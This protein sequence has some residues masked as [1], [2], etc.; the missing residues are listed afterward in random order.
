MKRIYSTRTR[1]VAAVLL[2]VIVAGGF[3][4]TPSLRALAQEIIDF[5]TQTETDEQPSTVFVG[6]GLAAPE[7]EYVDPYTLSLDEIAA[8]AGFDVF[9]PTYIPDIMNFKGGL[10]SHGG[11]RV[12]MIYDCSTPWSLMIAQLK[13]DD[14]ATPLEVGAS[15]VIEAVPIRD[16]IGQYVQGMWQYDVAPEIIENQ[17]EAIEE[18]PVTRV[19]VNELAWKR[20]LWREDGI[21]FTIMTAGGIMNNDTLSPC[22]LTKADYV[23]IAEGL[24]PA[25]TIGQ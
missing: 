18:V 17:G 3:W 1:L 13:V 16:S 6:S 9:L 5:F 22:A 4:A 11:Q 24:Q 21:N 19:W 7:E 14:L 10:V 8:Q 2:G 25:S 15:A 12:E 23:A 20:L